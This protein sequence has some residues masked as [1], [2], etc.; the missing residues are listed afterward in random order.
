M[1]VVGETHAGED[2]ETGEE[3]R[4]RQF[5]DLLSNFGKLVLD[6]DPYQQRENKGSK[7]DCQLNI[8]NLE[9]MFHDWLLISLITSTVFPT[10]GLPSK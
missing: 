9:A 3:E 2:D 10:I 4:S 1:I 6:S 7:G 8:G 5:P